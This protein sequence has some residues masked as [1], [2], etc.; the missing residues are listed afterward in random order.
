MLD[1]LNNKP[2]PK[3]ELSVTWILVTEDS[4]HG[5]YQFYGLLVEKM[6]NQLTVFHKNFEARCQFFPIPSLRKRNP[7][8]SGAL[9]H[10]ILSK[11]FKS[12][13]KSIFGC[14]RTSFLICLPPEFLPVVGLLTQWCASTLGAALLCS[15]RARLLIR[16]LYPDWVE[17]FINWVFRVRTLY[18]CS[19]HVLFIGRDVTIYMSYT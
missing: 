10:K 19:V 17:G 11:Y 8:F 6:S 5:C 18:L 2:L 4:H 9:P 1:A 7:N 12:F 14:F 16:G 13:V 15:S 3:S